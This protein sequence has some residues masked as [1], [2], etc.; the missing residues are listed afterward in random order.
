MRS[1]AEVCD[2]ALLP[3]VF[4]LMDQTEIKN[5]LRRE[6][7]PRLAA[8]SAGLVPGERR[9]LGVRLPVLRQLA[10]QLAK[11]DW[12]AF[13]QKAAD[14]TVEEIL[15]QGYILG[16]ARMPLEEAL[17]RLAA[18]VPKMD[19]W[20]LC[21]SVCASLRFVP[22]HRAEVWN[23]L[24]P[25]LRETDEFRLRFGV[26]MLLS[27]FVTD[28][29]IMRV[30]EVLD[31]LRPQFYYDRM[32]V[33]WALQVCFA[34][35]PAPTL[36]LLQT[37]CMDDNTYNKALQKILESRRTPEPMRDVI[38]SMKRSV[39]GKKERESRKNR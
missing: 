27:H 23:F 8:F 13:L 17:R 31:S 22:R 33:A 14:D 7:D 24:Q 5:F 36:Q 18:F 34:K 2:V 11:D 10:R 15:L 16:Y 3:P 1:G 30:L 6:A 20:M 26:I 35:F 28:E 9:L 38:R 21:D 29:Y 12:R 4:Q 39:R 37:T 32:A 19:N 25:Y